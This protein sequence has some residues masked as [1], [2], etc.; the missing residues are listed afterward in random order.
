MRTSS[1]RPT[2]PEPSMLNSTGCTPGCPPSPLRTPRES[3][4]RRRPSGVRALSSLWTIPEL[5]AHVADSDVVH[6]RWL[7]EKLGDELL[8]AA[9]LYTG[10]VAYRQ[11][12]GIAVIPVA[13]LGP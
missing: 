9:V 8:D 2:S 12:D 1:E 13:L 4:R 10:N 11:A 5:S 7:R 3:A 6:L